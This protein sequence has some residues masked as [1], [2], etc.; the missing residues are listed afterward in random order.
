[1]V[2]TFTFTE[3]FNARERVPRMVDD[4]PCEEGESTATHR[5]PGH[6]IALDN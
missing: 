4:V 1:M 6:F 3:C 5:A 2:T